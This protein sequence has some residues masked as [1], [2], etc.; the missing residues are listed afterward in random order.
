MTDAGVARVVSG[1]GRA[2]RPPAV[3]RRRLADRLRR[4]QRPAGRA[5]RRAPDG[6]GLPHLE[7][8]GH[9]LP[10]PARAP[11]RRRRRRRRRCWPPSTRRRRSWATPARSAARTT[12]TPTWSTGY[13]SGEL[14]ALPQ[15]QAGPRRQLARRRRAA[16]DAVPEPVP[17]GA[18]GRPLRAVTFVKHDPAPL[19][20]AGLRWL[21]EA[22]ARVP[23]DRRRDARAA[24]SSSASRPAGWTRRARRSSAGCWP[25]CTRAGA[26]RFGSLPGAGP[27]PRR[28]LRARIARGRRL[29]RVLPAAPVPAAGPAGRDS[30]A[31]S[32][33][34]GSTRRSSRWPGC[35]AT[36]GRATCWP[37]AT[38]GPG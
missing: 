5:V 26:P 34:C 31:R 19:E 16:A 25:R 29:E 24:W 17:R 22:G 37:T 4:G 13:T 6:Q 3:H 36:C 33:R 1:P 2:A 20:A 11:A 14:A 12:S 8:H 30:S 38:A 10:A 15:G 28:A 23:R 21:A 27:V 18:G 35:T 9:R 32:P 7:R